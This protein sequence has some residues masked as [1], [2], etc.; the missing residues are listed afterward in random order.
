MLVS[1]NRGVIALL[2]VIF[3]FTHA[4]IFADIPGMPQTD[5]ARVVVKSGTGVRTIADTLKADGLISS[6]W[7]F[8]A[9]S[10]IYRGQLI[11]GEYELRK[12]M[13]TME[14]VKKMGRGERTI[15]TLKI[16]EGHNLFNVADTID[17]AGIMKSDEFIALARNRSFL[18]RLGIRGD[19][20]EGYLAPD[21]YFYSR[22][23]EA[24]KLIE[25][26]AQKTIKFFAR[27]DI[28]R[29]MKEMGLDVSATLTLASM[30]E[31]EAKLK[32]EKPT[33]SAVFH[34]RLKKGMSLDCDPTV[35]YGMGVFDA[36]I[37]KSD[38]SAYTPYNTYVFKGL[39]RGPICN[40][41]RDSIMAVL[42]PASTD[43]LYFVS[44]ND[45][46]HVFSRDMREHNRYVALYQRA[47]NKKNHE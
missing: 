21:T 26:V 10:L 42:H 33:I 12:D 19:S 20:V 45:G 5:V 23:V 15:Y 34:N 22:E 38:L 46:S 43:Y 2:T 7:L 35:L 39:P 24:E 8:M 41:D 11:A 29:S 25:R 3:L 28:V 14:I 27:E 6:S 13:S 9:L 44:K 36:P 37:K 18:E 4:V 47:K 31:R 16:L 17:K 32:E 40:P 30:I 1:Q